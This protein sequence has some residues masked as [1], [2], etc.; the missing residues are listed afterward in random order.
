MNILLPWDGFAVIELFFTVLSRSALIM[1]H[2]LSVPRK[3][4]QRQ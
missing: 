3:A 1:N 4:F 2:R